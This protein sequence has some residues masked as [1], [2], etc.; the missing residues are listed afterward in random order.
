M[1]NTN[2]LTIRID[3]DRKYWLKATAKARGMGVSKLMTTAAAFYLALEPEFIEAVEKQAEEVGIMPGDYLS[4]LVTNQLAMHAAFR[5]TF[6]TAGK[7]MLRPFTRDADGKLLR[8]RELMEH[9]LGIYLNLYS[10][11]KEKTEKAEM[12]QKA[13]RVSAEAVQN[14]VAQKEMRPS[15]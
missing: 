5:L 14:V 2:R 15:V 6:G 1:K 10:D 3:D 11:F 8:G 12:N 4:G 9:L 13:F 7:A